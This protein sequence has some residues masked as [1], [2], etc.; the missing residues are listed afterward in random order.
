LADAGAWKVLADTDDLYR[1]MRAAE[2][3]GLDA[4][5]T[6]A[7][8]LSWRETCSAQSLAAVL[9]HRVRAIAEPLT[10]TPRQPLQTADPELTAFAA[11]LDILMAEREA[12]IAEHAVTTQPLW[13]TRA[14]GPLPED[15]AGRADWQERAGKLGA[16]RELSGIEG[17]DALGPR[18]ATTF[19]E[20]RAEW[21]RAADATPLID[22]MDLRHLTEGQLL[23]RRAAFERETAWAPPHAGRELGVACRDADRYRLRS[24]RHSQLAG[25]AT[26]EGTARLHRDTAAVC[27]A[28]AE[29]S[30]QVAS[31]LSGIQ[32]TRQEWD[33]LTGDTRR[34]AVAADTELRRRGLLPD[35]DQLKSAEHDAFTYEGSA[36]PGED[37]VRSVL[38]LDTEGV[39]RPVPER[40]SDLSLIAGRAQLR[41]D[42]LRT[43]AEPDHQGD[44]ELQPSEAWAKLV[45]R[46]RQSVL[47][48]PS[49]RCRS[50]GALPP[51]LGSVTMP[52]SKPRAVSIGTSSCRRSD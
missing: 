17:P 4:Q 20:M 30:R 26:G 3:A 35:D 47:Q 8:A 6:L 29:R 11:R 42:E 19:P 33:A 52:G 14:L 25:A 32:Q 22:G 16:W 13:V 9:T 46:D 49:L 2:I 51:M 37:Q 24:V 23:T 21:Q 18:P 43:M 40:I 50:P 7:E 48:A 5:S 38:G 34:V 28:A 1:V 10:P 31:L 44:D 41:I 39:T 36:E 45:G 12:R 27:A 15:Q